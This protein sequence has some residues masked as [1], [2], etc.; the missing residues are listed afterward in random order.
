LGN[1]GGST[2]SHA[3]I[4]ACCPTPIGVGLTVRK[5]YTGKSFAYAFGI[6][7]NIN[8]EEINIRAIAVIFV[9]FVTKFFDVFMFFL[10]LNF[11]EKFDTL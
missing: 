11:S 6:A 1:I 10:L 3:T 5:A 4:R 9:L 7:L 2:S 8:A